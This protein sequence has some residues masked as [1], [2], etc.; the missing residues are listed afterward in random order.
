[1]EGTVRLLDAAQ[2]NSSNASE[3]VYNPW[4]NDT[5]Q[6]RYGPRPNTVM[7][8]VGLLMRLYTGWSRDHEAIRQGADRLLDRLPEMKQPPAFAGKGNPLR[9]TYY[10]YN[11]TQV[12]FHMQGEHWRQ[13][14]DRLYP[15]LAETQIKQGDLVG[16]WHPREP[17]VDRWGSSAGRLYLTAM[18]LLS[19]EVYHRHLPLFDAGLSATK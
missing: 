14:R 4:G 17:V 10:W 19:L 6:G 12:M 8:A 9:D 11:A 2:I 3:Y 16:S 1:M 5:E 13:W 18:N 15:M 7:T